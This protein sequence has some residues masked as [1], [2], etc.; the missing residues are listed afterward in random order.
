M[1][2]VSIFG[3][4]FEAIEPPDN[5][6]STSNKVISQVNIADFKLRVLSA[7]AHS[8]ARRKL[9]RDIDD[10]EDSLAEEQSS[11]TIN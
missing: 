2:L 4:G 5:I 6:S 8:E 11:M 10:K 1:S 3:K 9:E 7:L